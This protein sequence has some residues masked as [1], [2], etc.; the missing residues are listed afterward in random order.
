MT[1][2]NVKKWLYRTKY[3]FWC[4]HF[5]LICQILRFDCQTFDFST[6][7]HYTKIPVEVLGHYWFCLAVVLLVLN[8]EGS[9]VLNY[10]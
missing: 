5:N 7:Q 1:Y 4:M 8:E 2:T 9:L 3:S 10:C 6:L